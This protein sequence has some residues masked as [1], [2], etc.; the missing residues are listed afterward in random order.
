VIELS[1]NG[2]SE[3]HLSFAG[4]ACQCNEANCQA[5]VIYCSYQCRLRA[6]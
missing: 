2:A 5:H 3:S 1:S 4:L 6:S